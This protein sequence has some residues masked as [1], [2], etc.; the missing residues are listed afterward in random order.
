MEEYGDACRCDHSSGV[1]VLE[2]SAEIEMVI[3]V[4][5]RNDTAPCM[6]GFHCLV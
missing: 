5:V 6:V 3:V 1:F 2:E 4:A